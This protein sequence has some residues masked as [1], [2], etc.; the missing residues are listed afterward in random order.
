MNQPVL[1]ALCCKGNVVDGVG[2]V[3]GDFQA[4]VFARFD[5]RGGDGVGDHGRFDVALGNRE[6]G[7]VLGL[8]RA[9]TAAAPFFLVLLQRD[10]FEGAAGVAD[11]L[12][13]EVVVAA[14]ACVF[15][16]QHD[17][18]EREIRNGHAD[19]FGPFQCVRGRGHNHVG[20]T[21]DQRRDAIRERGFNHFGRHAKHLR[22]VVAVIHIEP[23]RV[24]FIIARAHGREVQR[25]RAAQFAGVDDVIELVGLR[26]V[27]DR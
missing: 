1:V 27:E 8:V 9:E 19:R 16:G 23:D 24:V 20:T 22:Q 7:V 15:T 26:S 10:G 25:H 13:F 12:A 18:L 21:R 5:R 11:V 6:N 3:A 4:F 2:R 17:H 14:D